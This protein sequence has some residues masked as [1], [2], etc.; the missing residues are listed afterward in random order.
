V[1]AVVGFELTG[2]GH[3]VSRPRL[4]HASGGEGEQG[5]RSVVVTVPEGGVA[6]HALAVPLMN[7]ATQVRAEDQRQYG[8]GDLQHADLVS[9][10]EVL[11]RLLDDTH[12]WHDLFLGK[13]LS[14]GLSRA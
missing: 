3:P 11:H 9:R 13:D 14:G 10:H 4:L 12:E 7:P 1:A 5:L 2:E 6:F 8:Y